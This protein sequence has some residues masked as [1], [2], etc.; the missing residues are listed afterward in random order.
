ML[1]ET[2][3]AAT[4][5]SWTAPFVA[6]GALTGGRARLKRHLAALGPVDVRA[7]PY[8]E[9]VLRHI[10]QRR[11]EG[12][13]VALVTASDQALADRIA[14]HLGV[15]DWVYGS[16][17]GVNL[18]GTHKARFLA[19]RFPDGFQYM[20]DSTAD[21][22]VWRGA[23]KAI[24]VTGSRSL[25]SRVEGLG[26]PVEH[27]PTPRVPARCYLKA[28]QPRDWLVNLTIFLPLLVPGLTE[29]AY[30][31]VITGFVAFCLVASGLALVRPLLDRHAV[32]AG[33]DGGAG[34]PRP[35]IPIAHATLLGM[36]L[37]PAGVG[38]GLAAG[39]LPSLVLAVFAAIN[40]AEARAGRRRAGALGVVNT[41]L[42]LGAGALAAGLTVIA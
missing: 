27:L 41:A 10:R 20:G 4:A 22:K 25:K 30:V 2:F 32:G 39:V 5:A 15:F 34:Q 36:A 7:L 38:L 28:L 21:L 14:R 42:R 11:A 17:D 9:D 37:I 8:N 16:G 24:T 12:I 31:P 13:G 26:C 35:G 19:R 23:S 3:W 1:Y 18:K 33:K 29:R 40:L 6:L